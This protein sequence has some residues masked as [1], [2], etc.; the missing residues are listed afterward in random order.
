[1]PSNLGLIPVCNSQFLQD[2]TIALGRRSLKS[3]R[4][5]HSRLEFSCRYEELDGVRFERLDIQAHG[6]SSGLISL[7]LWEDGLGWIYQKKGRGKSASTNAFSLHS[8]FSAMS[9]EAVASLVHAT[10][11]DVESSKAI[12]R[13]HMADSKRKRD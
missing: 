3:I 10:L 11:A 8:D 9:A 13:E 12:W 7:T 5:H 6:L 2:V 4:Y 1:M